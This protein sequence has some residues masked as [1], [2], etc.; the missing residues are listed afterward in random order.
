M[1][2]PSSRTVTLPS[3]FSDQLAVRG[4]A[5]LRLVHR[6]VDDLEGHVV[7]ARAIVGVADIHARALAHRIE[8]LAGRR[9]MRRHRHQNRA[10]ARCLRTCRR[11][12]PG[13]VG[14]YSRYIAATAPQAQGLPQFSC[15]KRVI[16][17]QFAIDCPCR[18]SAH[19]ASGGKMSASVPVSQRLRRQCGERGEQRL[20][21]RRVEMGRELVQQQHRC[22][23]RATCDQRACRQHDAD[24]QRFLLAGRCQRG[25]HPGHRPGHRP[26]AEVLRAHRTDPQVGAVVVAVGEH[27]AAGGPC[28]LGEAT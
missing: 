20:P 25:R 22:C 3:P 13:A 24:Q 15:G 12:T 16:P 17:Q 6:V 8:A 9:W 18:A 7:Q 27:R 23:P 11:T 4:K 10:A 5:G 19:P 28:R 1:P 21:P 26:G 14:G 2:R